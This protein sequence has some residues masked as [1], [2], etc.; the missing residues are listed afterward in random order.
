MNIVFSFPGQGTQ[1][2]G[3][4]KDVQ[5]CAEQAA[6][7]LGRPLLDD[8][9]SLQST[10]G[11]QLALFVKETAIAKQLVKRGILP[12]F[13]AGH[14][15]GAFAAA[16]IADVIS[17]EDGLRLVARRAQLMEDAYPEGYGMGIILGLTKSEVQQAVDEA[18]SPSV[19]VYLSNLNAEQQ[20]AV[21]GSLEGINNAFK[22]A[23]KLGAAKTILM[24]VPIPSHSPLMKGVS[25][26]LT[27]LI[28]TFSLKD[29][30]IP[31]LANHTGRM[32][33]AKDKIAEDLALNVTYPVRWLDMST[34]CVEAGADCF[35][36]MPPGRTL[37]N[38]VKQ[39]HPNTRQISVCEV[40]VEATHYLITKWKEQ[41]E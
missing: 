39:A 14:S 26:D 6:A 12:Q 15:I 31:Y 18:H 7:I 20:I 5:E 3:M 27:K 25:Q 21:S 2:T 28:S 32:I 41:E 17:F 34:V 13:V 35:I 29:A 11:I 24:K 38:L 1:V 4:L 23:T 30:Q 10:V 16:V 19:P 33:K 36:E 8:S 40:G 37:S 22:Y 9:E